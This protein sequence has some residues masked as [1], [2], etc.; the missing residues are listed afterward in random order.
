MSK[1]VQKHQFSSVSSLVMKKDEV[2]LLVRDS[3]LI[4]TMGNR[5]DIW[6]IKPNNPLVQEVLPKTNFLNTF[7]NKRKLT[8]YLL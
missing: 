4:L 2:R 3:A 1:L 5:K 8:V 7:A 6:P